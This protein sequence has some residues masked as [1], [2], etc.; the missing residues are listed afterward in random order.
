[1]FLCVVIS[2]IPNEMVFCFCF[3][4]IAEETAQSGDK[5]DEAVKEERKAEEQ[6]TSAKEDK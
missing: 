3:C 2:C 6:T 5:K 1:M 4:G